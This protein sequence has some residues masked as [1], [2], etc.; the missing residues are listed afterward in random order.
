MITLELKN[1]NMEQI[2]NSGQCFRMNR[3]GDHGYEVIAGEHYLDLEQEGDTCRFDCTQQEFQEFWSPYFDLDRNYGAYIE[4]IDPTDEYLTTVAAYGSG[5]RILKQDLWEMIVS[6]LI[7]QQNNITRIRRCIGNICSRY[8]EKKKNPNG[9]AYDAF[10]TPE[11]LAAA[12]DEDLKACNLG[13]RS[14][15]V[16]RTAQSIVSGEV[17]LE[18]VKG[19]EYDEA[20]AE[21]MK[22]Y[23]VGGKVADCICL[24]ALQKLEAFPVDT[25]IRQALEKYY[26]HGFPMERYQGYEG[27]LQQYIFY[28]DLFGEKELV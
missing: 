16:I 4:S 20:K 7:S 1:F 26:Q 25:H 22:L 2:C 18:A 17:S 11:A 3:I 24:F 8:G 13:Y 12:T 28:Y 5:I 6:F 14:K 10:P 23:G 19:M 9:V 15:Y 27:V 21:L